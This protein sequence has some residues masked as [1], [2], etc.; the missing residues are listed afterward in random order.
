VLSGKD[1]YLTESCKRLI[2]FDIAMQ[3]T[4]VLKVKESKF[5][6]V[7]REG[8]VTMLK[9]EIAHGYTS[10]KDKDEFDYTLK[11]FIQQL[12]HDSMQSEFRQKAD[13]DYRVLGYNSISSDNND[14]EEEEE[15]D[16][17]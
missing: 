6:Q 10:M 9:S 13:S 4:V 7:L 15:N 14:E 8:K 11:E 16:P 1:R 2:Y 17:P 3:V 12:K 5:L